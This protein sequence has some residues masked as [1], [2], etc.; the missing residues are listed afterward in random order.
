MHALKVRSLE[1]L[2]EEHLPE[3]EQWPQPL[4]Q[5]QQQL[6]D[7]LSKLP[8]NILKPRR[9]PSATSHVSLHPLAHPLQLL[10][11]HQHG[12]NDVGAAAS[13]EVAQAD[14]SLAGGVGHVPRNPEQLSDL[15]TNRGRAEVR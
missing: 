14:G 7:S 9:A 5:Q 15:A 2:P 1:A 12:G 8:W 11:G 13:T 3:C 4:Q 10:D 6:A